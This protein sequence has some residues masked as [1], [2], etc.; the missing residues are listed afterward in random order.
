MDK[1]ELVRQQSKERLT[2][3]VKKRINTTMIGAIASVE[4][5]FGKLWGFNSDGELNYQQQKMKELFEELRADILDK[6]NAQIRQ[7]EAELNNYDIN[8]NRYHI[9]ILP[10]NR[11]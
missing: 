10:I 11:R 6:G 8:W 7:F 9:T 1:K 5:H 4:E 3:E 2:K